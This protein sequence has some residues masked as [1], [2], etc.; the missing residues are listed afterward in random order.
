MKSAFLAFSLLL[1]PVLAAQTTLPAGTVLPVRL[2]TGLNARHL[3]S[4][5]PVRAT[6]MQNIPG[7]AIHRGARVLGEVVAASPTRLEVRFD[8]L[9][10][11][12]RRIPLK[13]NLRAI[14]SMVEVEEAQDPEG[15]PDRGTPPVWYTTQQVG[16]EQVYRG[17][18]PVASGLDVVGVPTPYGVRGALRSNG[19]CRGTIAGNTQQQALWIFSTNACGAYGFE[20]LTVEHYG[21]TSPEG[22]IALVSKSGRLHIRSGS[23]LLLR[24]QGS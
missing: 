12:G 23:G 17:G 6:V 4:G 11:H 13:T 3:K 9:D 19:P 18:G 8:T 24:V 16:G 10:L 2:D 5:Q 21:R 20:D 15:G 22:D 14:A 7:T 1:A